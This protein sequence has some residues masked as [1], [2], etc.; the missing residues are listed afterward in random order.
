VIAS[1]PGGIYF[2]PPTPP[3]PNISFVAPILIALY[4]GEC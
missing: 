1:M 3:E 2:L 4:D